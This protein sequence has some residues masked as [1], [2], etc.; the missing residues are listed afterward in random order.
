MIVF[1]FISPC[2]KAANLPID[3]SSSIDAPSKV[4]ISNPKLCSSFI[5]LKVASPFPPNQQPTF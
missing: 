5:C 1:V 4:I 3:S 2:H